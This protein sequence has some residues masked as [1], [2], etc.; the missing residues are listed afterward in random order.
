[1]RACTWN[2]VLRERERG[3]G[4]EREGEKSG[5]IC[6]CIG[7]LER[8]SRSEKGEPTVNRVAVEGDKG[9]DEAASA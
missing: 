5:E 4:R 7:A 3:G 8:S 6:I 1:V 2:V 9:R